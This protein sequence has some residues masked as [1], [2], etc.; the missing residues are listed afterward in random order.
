MVVI[1][2]GCPV[3]ATGPV[4]WLVNGVALHGSNDGLSY[5]GFGV[6]QNIAFE[7]NKLDMDVC[8]GHS[9]SIYPYHRK[10]HYFA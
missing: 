2:A 7:F 9:T 5:N 10:M 1:I 6:W 8:S 4:G 3:N